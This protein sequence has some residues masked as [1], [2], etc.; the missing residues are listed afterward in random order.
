M[1]IP[2]IIGSVFK[3]FID[4]ETFNFNLDFSIL[5]LGFF[6]SFV[7]GIIACNGCCHL[8]ENFKLKFFSFYCVSWNNS[9]KFWIKDTTKGEIC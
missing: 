3:S 4:Q 6:V 5:L 9:S 2:L 8:V 7:T 1:V